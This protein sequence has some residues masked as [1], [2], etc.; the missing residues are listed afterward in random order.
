MPIKASLVRGIEEY[1]DLKKIKLSRQMDRHGI[2][3]T[4]MHAGQKICINPFLPIGQ[5]FVPN[6][7]ILIKCLIDFFQNAVEQDVNLT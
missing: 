5:F 4:S 6:L 3:I 2:V 7:I 1:H